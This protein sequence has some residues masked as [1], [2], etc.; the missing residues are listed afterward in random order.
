MGLARVA[1]R[2]A[3]PVLYLSL[4]Y[5]VSLTPKIP[6]TGIYGLDKV[7]HFAEFGCLGLLLSRACGAPPDRNLWWGLFVLGLI[8]GGVDELLQR[9]VPGRQS[10]AWDFLADAIGLTVGMSL[11]ARF[12]RIRLIR[13]LAWTTGRHG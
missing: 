7:L 4:V 12:W 2:W 13:R 9:G 11:G 8:G 3:P 10:S 1:W 6:T 5:A